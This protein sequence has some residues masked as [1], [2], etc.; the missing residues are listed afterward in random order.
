MIWFWDKNSEFVTDGERLQ[1][2]CNELYGW[3][4]L[5]VVYE[6]LTFNTWDLPAGLCDCLLKNK[7]HLLCLLREDINIL[8]ADFILDDIIFLH[9]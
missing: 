1:Y 8:A 9:I 6:I 2:V 3:P 5:L 4:S 7:C